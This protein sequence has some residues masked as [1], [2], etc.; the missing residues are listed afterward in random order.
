MLKSLFVLLAEH[1]NKMKRS[2]NHCVSHFKIEFVLLSN[3]QVF[4][5]HQAGIPKTSSV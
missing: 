2:I 3:L 4:L 1:E 5:K